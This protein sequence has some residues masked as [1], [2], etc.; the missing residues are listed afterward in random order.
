[1]GSHPDRFCLDCYT[2]ELAIR[3]SATTY[4]RMT[5]DTARLVL[6]DLQELAADQAA[7]VVA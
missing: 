4:Q 7:E 2:K 6:V 1:M 5:D 3:L